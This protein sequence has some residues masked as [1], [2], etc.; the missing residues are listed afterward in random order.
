[1]Q[2]TEVCKSGRQLHV[3][4]NGIVLCLFNSLNGRGVS[5][6]ALDITVTSSLQQLNIHHAADT[7]GYALSVGEDRKVQV[8]FDDYR[9]AGIFFIP[10]VVES[11]GGCNVKCLEVIDY[12]DELKKVCIW[13]S[14]PMLQRTIFSTCQM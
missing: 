13:A 8:H 1:M 10:L 5:Y 7:S 2:A 14:S 3:G 6:S 9:D 12:R 4:I 11:F